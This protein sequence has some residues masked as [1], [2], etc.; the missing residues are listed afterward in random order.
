MAELMTKAEYARRVGKSKTAIRNWELSGMIKMQ[1]DMV[2]VQASD[3]Y[4]A[5]YH[6]N[7]RPVPQ[8]LSSSL[9]EV[10]YREVEDRLASL[11]WNQSFQWDEA[12]LLQRAK[13]A[14]ACLGFKLLD[15]GFKND[16][17]ATHG[18]YQVRSEDGDIIQAGYGFE[19]DLFDVIILCRENALYHLIEDLVINDGVQ[20]RVDSLPSI[21][22]P[23]F[24]HQTAES[25]GGQVKNPIYNPK[26]K[27]QAH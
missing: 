25:I 12:A 18:G 24:Q 1:G 5:K 9:V 17:L 19:L 26:R 15:N 23:I 10:D 4:L 11:D 21:A 16:G 27:G 3:D 22:L 14:C 6:I 7:G 20:L 2:D 8:K 13:D